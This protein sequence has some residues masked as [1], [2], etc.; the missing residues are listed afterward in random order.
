VHSAIKD[1]QNIGE[2]GI[3]GFCFVLFAGGPAL[4]RQVL[5]YLSHAPSQEL[6]F[7]VIFCNAILT[8]KKKCKH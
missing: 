4:L 5:Y 7:N 8:N 3:Y 2:N 6:C 1:I